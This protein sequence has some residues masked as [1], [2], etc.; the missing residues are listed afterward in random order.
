MDKPPDLSRRNFLLRRGGTP[1]PEP[2]PTWDDFFGD[3]ATACAQVNEARPFL[4]DDAARLGI[5]TEGM[6]DVEVLKAIFATTG[7]PHG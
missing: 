2:A 5:D 6:T 7:Q 4:A 3:Y 1:E